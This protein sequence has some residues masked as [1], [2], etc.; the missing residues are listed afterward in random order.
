MFYLKLLC[1]NRN[2]NENGSRM[3]S[4]RHTLSPHKVKMKYQLLIKMSMGLLFMFYLF[5]LELIAAFSELERIFL[6]EKI[7]KVKIFCIKSLCRL[8]EILSTGTSDNE[9]SLV[10]AELK[11]GGA[12]VLTRLDFFLE[13]QRRKIED[14][15]SMSNIAC[16]LLNARILII[17]YLLST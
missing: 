9:I 13:I 11:K 6:L 17:E 4:D 5:S 15:Q 3:Q 8:N 2:S 12:V 10:H 1:E 7:L 16:S 14:I